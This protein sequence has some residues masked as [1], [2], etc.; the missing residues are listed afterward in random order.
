M[1]FCVKS[2]L[3][4]RKERLIKKPKL[5]FV[6]IFS[7]KFVVGARIPENQQS[8]NAQI[9]EFASGTSRF[10]HIQELT[11]GTQPMMRM[12][13]TSTGTPKR[14][15][16]RSHRG[17]LSPSPSLASARKFFQPQPR[18]DTQNST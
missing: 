14:I 7:K 5:D 3:H 11:M 18:R 13:T 10:A 9:P 2:C 16:R 12:M 6:T 4:D 1:T 17:N 8:L 15:H